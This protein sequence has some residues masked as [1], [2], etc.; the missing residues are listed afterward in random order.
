MPEDDNELTEEGEQAIK[1]VAKGGGIVFIGLLIS[2]FLGYLYRMVV[3][4]FLGPEQYG[5][6]SLG[7]AVVGFAVPVALLGLHQGVKRYAS[8]Y[9][10]KGEKEKVKG[11]I[12]STFKII[13]PLSIAVAVLVF[14]LS[15]FLAIRIFDEPAAS[16]VFK[17]FA[18]SIPFQVLLRGAS[19]AIESF[20]EMKYSVIARYITRNTSKIILTVVL[21][22]LGFEVLREAEKYGSSYN[23]SCLD[24]DVYREELR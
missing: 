18:V 5:L 8:Y 22:F 2:R 20:K 15:D 24:L 9:N 16:L 11:T 3:G 6:I 1:S 13:T 12:I 21:L 14:F 19:Q 4:R 10:G 7:M 23:L 17:I